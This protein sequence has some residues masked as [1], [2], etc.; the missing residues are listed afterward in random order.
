MIRMPAAGAVP[1]D[2]ALISTAIEL[3]VSATAWVAVIVGLKFVPSAIRACRAKLDVSCELLMSPP[4]T[5]HPLPAD[6]AV[7]AVVFWPPTSPT[8]SIE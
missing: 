5:V 1:A 3:K 2:A 8:L 4:S 7:T 6:H